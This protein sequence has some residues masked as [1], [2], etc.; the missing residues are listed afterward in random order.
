[1][2]KLLSPQEVADQLGVPLRTVYSWN[3]KGTGPR[4][5]RIGKHV[6]YRPSDVEQWL[7]DHATGEA[8]TDAA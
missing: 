4:V 5:H 3:H 7:A 1:M 6:R 8:T 2:E